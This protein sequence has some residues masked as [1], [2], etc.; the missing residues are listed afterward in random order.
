MAS[1]SMKF[2]PILK[3]IRI[4]LCQKSKE[5][6]GIREFIE[7]HYVPIKKGNPKFPILVRECL[8][9]EP[10]IYARYDFGKETSVS[11]NNFNA[12]KILEVVQKLA[13][14]PAT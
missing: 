2:A 11:V 6:L 8:G 4:H 9:V 7:K 3:E 1:K 12:E 13:K 14:G 5:S 10:K